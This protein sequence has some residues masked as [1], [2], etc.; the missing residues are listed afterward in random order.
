MIRRLL[1]SLCFASTILHS[2]AYSEELK[3]YDP[4]YAGTLLAFFAT[5]VDP[6]HLA[7]QPY[8]FVT[9]QPGSYDKNWAYQPQPATNKLSALVLAETGITSFMDLTLQV[10]E[11]YDRF[12]HQHFFLYQDT[13]TFLGFQL[14]RDQKESWTPDFRLLLGESFPTGKYKNLN[15]NYQLSDSSGSGS[16]QTSVVLVSRKIFYAIPNHPFNINLNL[17]YILSSKAHVQGYNVYGGDASTRGK[18][19]VGNQFLTNIALEY[20]F[21]RNWVVGLDMRYLHQ[22]KSVFKGN[23]KEGSASVGTPSSEQFS[24]APCIEY[25]Y[26]ANLGVIAGAWFTVAGRNS[27]SMRSGV[28]SAFYS[29]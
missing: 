11:S 21:T 7:I 8:L 5:N 15:P 9:R 22:N 1:F 17:E 23:T 12:E 4:L 24:I 3:S 27:Q 26:N 2:T 29:F 25:N 28:L 18:V 6:G 19:R 13:Q 14:A 20:S 16:Y 10:N